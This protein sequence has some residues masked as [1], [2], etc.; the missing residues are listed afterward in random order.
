[1]IQMKQVSKTY[2]GDQ[3]ETKV[4]ESVDL[5]VEK[6]EFVSLYGKS[7]CGKTTLLNLLGLIDTPTAGEYWLDEVNTGTC[8][9]KELARLRNRKIGFIFQSFYLISRLSVLDNVILPMKY[10]GVPRKEREERAR[11][12][13][14][15]VGLTE[16][17]SYLPSRLSG[18]EK[19][20]TAIARA[21]ANHPAYILADEPTGSLDGENRD[22][23]MEILTG[24]NQK[25]HTIVMVTHDKELAGYSSRI[26]QM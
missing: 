9:P 12:L 19:Q 17:M 2:Y 8:K 20:R 24:L 5:T 21:L 3:V 25:G 15:E 1:M 14:A 22:R 16:R 13:L 6:G 4:L 18:G 11:V 7:G 26:I 23:I 10:A